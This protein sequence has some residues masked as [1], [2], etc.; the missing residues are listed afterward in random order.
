MIRQ[1]NKVSPKKN[2]KK[3]RLVYTYILLLAA[4]NAE[5]G[6]KPL[7]EKRAKVAQVKFTGS[8]VPAGTFSPTCNH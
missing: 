6:G 4:P 7:A 8:T 5:L 3:N 1:K 2:W